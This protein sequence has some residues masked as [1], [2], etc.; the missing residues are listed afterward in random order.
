MRRFHIVVR[1]RR[2]AVLALAM[3]FLSLAGCAV[4][5]RERLP[6]LA[7]TPVWQKATL[8]QLLEKIRAQETFIQTL[9]ATVELQPSVTRLRTE[10][11]LY[12]RDVRAFILVRKPAFLRMIGQAPVVRNTLFDMAS[13]G[14]TFRLYI[15]SRNRFIMGKSQ[16][17]RRSESPLE[18][19]RPQH[20]L[21]ALLWRAPAEGEQAV[22]EAAQE[23]DKAFYVVHVLRRSGA[24]QLLLARNFWFERRNL[25]LERLQIFDED[26]EAVT[27]VRYADYAVFSGLAY[28]R[29]IL[30]DRP[31]DQFG[32]SL[33]VSQ[34]QWNEPLPDDKF[35]LERPAGADFINLEERSLPR[36]ATGV[37]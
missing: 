3:I 16:G 36:E 6:S 11:V 26:G 2:G 18:N 33:S 30:I 25:S 35:H 7:S 19:L 34:L 28:A 27:D 13:D 5:R 4:Q 12:Y 20:I 31:R 23:G 10:E 32:L 9:E 17:G 1:S 14:E 15:P 22:L 21:D 24:Q 37:G 29:H 8:E